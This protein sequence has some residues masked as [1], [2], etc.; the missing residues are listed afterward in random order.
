MPT[1]VV[2][3]RGIVSGGEQPEQS[4]RE[5]A[6]Y[7]GQRGIGIKSLRAFYDGHQGFPRGG[8]N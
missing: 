4:Q 7:V 3:Y 8:G 6:P 5:E 1:D 2:A